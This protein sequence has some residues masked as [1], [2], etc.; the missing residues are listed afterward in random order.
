MVVELRCSC[1]AFPPADARFCQQCG[2]KLL[3][4]CDACGTV[5]EPDARFCKQCGAGLAVKP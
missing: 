2:T 3:P 4:A 5:N 1:G